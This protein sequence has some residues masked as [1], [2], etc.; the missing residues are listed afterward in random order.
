MPVAAND[1]VPRIVHQVLLGD[2]HGSPILGA[3]ID[4]VAYRA[5]HLYSWNYEVWNEA[6]L[7]IAFPEHWPQLFS[8]CCHL[9]QASNV[10]RYLILRRHGGLYLDTDVELFQ[11]P[12]FISGAWIAGTSENPDPHQLNPC[13]L[14]APP[15]HPY[16]NRM[17]GA[18]ER[19]EVDLSGHMMAGP[20][21]AVEKYS[22]ED[23]SIWPAHVWHGRRGQQDALGHH[24]GWGPKLGSFLRRHKLPPTNDIG[25]AK[26]ES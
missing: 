22:S 18:I 2:K 12:L 19:G 8:Q 9:S 20:L 11:L 16:I 10:A 5:M 23:V 15:G 17:L 7:E 13:C 1:P 25:V 14:A 24:Y 4:A 6:A 26:P 21:L 3:F